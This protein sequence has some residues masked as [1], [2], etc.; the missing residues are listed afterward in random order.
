MT[1]V[2][3]KPLRFLLLM[4]LW[5]APAAE[6]LRF[7]LMLKVV[8]DA[9]FESR[10]GERIVESYDGMEGNEDSAEVCD[11]EMKEGDGRFNSGIP[12]HK[13]LTHAMNTIH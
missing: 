2:A 6:L 12:G 8:L 11:R 4:A 13:C 10:S 1:H 5:P 3:R 7:M 9:R